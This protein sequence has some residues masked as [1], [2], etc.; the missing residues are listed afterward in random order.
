MNWPVIFTV[1]QNKGVVVIREIEDSS[2]NRRIEI[3]GIDKGKGI[4]EEEIQT[5]V[6]NE[7]ARWGWGW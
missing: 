7:M 6:A 2:S 4:S 3:V 1:M 5:T